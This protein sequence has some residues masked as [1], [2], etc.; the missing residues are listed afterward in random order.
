MN[1]KRHAIADANGRPIRFFLPASRVRD[2]TG[3]AALLVSLPKAGWC[4]LAGAMTLSG[5]E[6]LKDKGMKPR[7]PGRKSRG[8]PIRLDKRRYLLISTE[9]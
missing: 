6:M 9:K 8:D 2:Q 4:W 1:T 5:S 7:I 3:A